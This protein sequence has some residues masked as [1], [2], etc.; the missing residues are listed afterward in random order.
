MKEQFSVQLF[1]MLSKFKVMKFYNL[2]YDA[3][4]PLTFSLTVLQSIPRNNKG[5]KSVLRNTNLVRI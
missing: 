1:T 2:F 3:H 4:N 5:R